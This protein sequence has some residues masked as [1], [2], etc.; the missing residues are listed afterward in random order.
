MVLASFVLNMLFHRICGFSTT[1]FTMVSA[2]V[3]CVCSMSMQAVVVF[4][5]GSSNNKLFFAKT[6]TW[7]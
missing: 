5:I 1:G 7:Q 3:Q 6:P 4:K 2:T